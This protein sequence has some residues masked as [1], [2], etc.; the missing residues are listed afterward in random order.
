MNN[1]SNEELIGI[2]G[3]GIS[4]KLILGL[5]GST[6]VFLIGV[7]DGIVSPKKCN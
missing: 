5:I 7:V 4:T 2:N 1:L 6:L 3:G